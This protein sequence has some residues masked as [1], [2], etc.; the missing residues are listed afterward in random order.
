MIQALKHRLGI[1]LRCQD[2]HH[3]LTDYFENALTEDQKW[4]FEQHL[5]LCRNC[6]A[7]LSRY[8]ATIGLLHEM[9]KT[10]SPPTE[11]VEHTIDFLKTELKKIS[12]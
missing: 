10:P 6:K 7:Y 9:P 3:F 5:R 4:R 1:D 11:L 12:L 2:A 8:K